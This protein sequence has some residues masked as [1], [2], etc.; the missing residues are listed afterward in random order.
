MGAERKSERAGNGAERQQ[1][2]GDTAPGDRLLSGPARSNV[3]RR[4]ARWFN[5]EEIA[6]VDLLFAE[7]AACVMTDRR[8]SDERIED[9]IHYALA[10]H[11]ADIASSGLG[12]DEFVRASIAQYEAW[13]GEKERAGARRPVVLSPWDILAGAHRPAKRSEKP[14]NVSTWDDIRAFLRLPR[15][16]EIRPD[17]R[18]RT[19][20][21]AGFSAPAR[22]DLRRLEVLAGT[23]GRYGGAI[24]Q[25][26]EYGAH[27]MLAVSARAG[28][29]CLRVDPTNFGE[30]AMGWAPARS[31][32]VPPIDLYRRF[33]VCD[34]DEETLD[35]VLPGGR[36]VRPAWPSQP[37]RRC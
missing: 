36:R 8:V 23:G 14:R 18:G 21:C 10:R 37:E 20:V 29:M 5:P 27:G 32:E 3:P 12:R 25:A 26:G 9:A 7:V 6:L 1:L 22:W 13:C 11:E 19:Y 33:G 35:V 16:V 4:I 17:D 31:T 15:S 24:V 28:L 34:L 2:S 30:L